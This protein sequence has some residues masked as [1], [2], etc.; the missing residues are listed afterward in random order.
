MTHSVIKIVN[1]IFATKKHLKGSKFTNLE[2]VQKMTL[3]T[4]TNLN[5]KRKNLNSFFIFPLT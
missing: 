4:K 5:V 1:E 3:P 2:S